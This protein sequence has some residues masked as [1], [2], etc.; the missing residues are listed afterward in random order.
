MAENCLKSLLEY[1]DPTGPDKRDALI[2]SL[3][4][5]SQGARVFLASRLRTGPFAE[6]FNEIYNVGDRT[7]NALVSVL[8]E[9][10]SWPTETSRKDY[11]RDVF[12]LLMAKVLEAGHVH[13]K[14]AVAGIARLLA[15]D[16]EHLQS[17]L[18]AETLDVI[19]SLLDY[20]L[21]VDVRSQATLAIAKYMEICQEKGPALLSDFVTS[22]VARQK[23]EDLIVAFSVA[24]A[25]FPIIPSVAAAL[26]LSEGFVQSLADVLKK[27]T[28]SKEVE[29]AVLEL[30]SAACMDGGCR[31]AIQKHC[32]E[33]LNK[34]LMNGD[35]RR[36]SEIAAVI[37]AKVN[38]ADRPKTDGEQ[39]ARDQDQVEML[40][41]KFSNMMTESDQTSIQSSIE[42]L[43]YLSLQPKMKE[44]LANDRAFLKNLLTVLGD[45]S[46]SST[47]VFGGL[48]II[49]NLTKYL[50]NR[51]EE[52]KRISQLK[53]YANSS[54]A[55]ST[56]HPLDEDTHV[57]QR[58]KAVLDA[59]IVPVL[60]ISAKKVSTTALASV[61]DILLSFSKTSNHRGTIAQQGGLKLLL[62]TYSSITGTNT[63]DI[64]ARRTAAH[65]V[66][67]ILISVNPAL[68]FSTSGQPQRTSAIRP[69]LSLLSSSEDETI[70][71]GPRDLLPIFESLLALTNLA[72]I[73][74]PTVADTI[75]RL[76]W[77]P[78]ED[79]LLSNN[80]LIQRATVELVCNLMLSPSGIAQFADGSPRAGQRLHIL[81]ALADVEDF[82]TRRAAGGALAVLTEDDAAVGAILDRERGVEKLLGLCNEDEEEEI[83][84]RGV[85]CVRNVV[86]AT[87]DVGLK[88]REKMKEMG[89]VEVLKVILKRT[90]NE[91]ILEEGVEALKI[92]LR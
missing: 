15:A 91:R 76:A 61:L 75:I 27:R 56:P 81:L 38:G 34:V 13:V 2:A 19:L 42:G 39:G 54:K 11:E 10:L 3:L 16:A 51:S 50:P 23:N 24:A 17:L 89:G 64:R 40:I 52:Q 84:R 80:T 5:Q 44:K 87:G 6:V 1:E 58:C 90:R 55:T 65:A 36:R 41:G 35:G 53:A 77:P 79:L 26:F 92:L 67:R 22:R 43:A 12:K 63:S 4:R 8:L 57:T 49:S 69:L 66:A 25:V 46:S 21:S 47:L 9:E 29:Q 71:D 85:V 60:V 78:I 59:G 48:N 33:W 31:Q 45:V 83:V 20:R 30:L 37:L 88:G 72:S 73:P 28:K 7:V 68:V 14:R 18:D 62:N 82:A 32:S 70:S 74:D 86:C